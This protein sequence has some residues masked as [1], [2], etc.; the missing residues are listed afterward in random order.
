L[1][2]AV[3]LQG[4][5][6]QLWCTHFN[7][8]PL[9]T[10]FPLKTGK[11]YKIFVDLPEKEVAKEIHLVGDLLVTLPLANQRFTVPGGEAILLS[12]P[13]PMVAAGCKNGYTPT[14][15]QE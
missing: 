8:Q 3:S 5:S 4:V 11:D 15:G 14:H 13:S 12:H 7:A 2:W 6:D 10:L 9:S 1:P